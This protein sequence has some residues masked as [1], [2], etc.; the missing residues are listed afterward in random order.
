MQQIKNSKLKQLKIH[1]PNRK[2]TGVVVSELNTIETS[3]HPEMV[4]D[5][6]R[7]TLNFDL[8]KFLLFLAR[9]KTYTHNK[10]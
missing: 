10:N 1:L 7:V 2:S 8:S 5:M 3:S 4:G 6:S 9:V